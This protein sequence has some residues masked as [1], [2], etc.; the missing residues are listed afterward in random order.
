MRQFLGDVAIH[1]GELAECDREERPRAGVAGE[2]AELEV[3]F[4]RR[5]AKRRFV[6]V[7]L[8]DAPAP[9]G[10]LRE[11]FHPVARRRSTPA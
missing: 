6:H 4:V 9:G 7:G 5:L 11:A 1:A 3:Q 2:L 8:T 10:R